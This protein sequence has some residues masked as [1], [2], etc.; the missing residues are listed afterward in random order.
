MI[1]HLWSV[2]CS[3]SIVD[4]DTNNISLFELIEDLTIE[5][6][7]GARLT[8]VEYEITSC[9]FRES[10]EKEEDN[11]YRIN[12]IT[13]SGKDKG[14]PEIKLHF[15]KGINRIRSRSLFHA[16]PVE[17]MGIHRFKISLKDQKG[18][19]KEVASIPITLKEKT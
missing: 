5:N 9:W 3:K 4:N 18:K 13:P 17:E 16:F 12:L 6:F 1:E 8:Q 7:S 19:Y 10:L 14:G 15:K 2:L 11:E